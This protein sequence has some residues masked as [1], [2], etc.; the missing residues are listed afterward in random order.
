[1]A[2]TDFTLIGAD[3]ADVSRGVSA[4]FTPPNGGSNYV[5]GF[6]S[7]ISEP[8]AVCAYYNA[9]NF[10]PLRDASSNAT[11]GSVRA[12]LKRGVAGAGYSI[13]LFINLQATVI[14]DSTY[15]LGLSNNDPYSIVLA[16]LSPDTPLDSTATHKLRVSSTNYSTQDWFHLRL[17]AIVNPNG[18]V[19]LK[20]FQNDLDTNPVTSPSWAAITGMDDIID[21]GL[22]ITSG[23]NPLSGG[24]AGYCFKAAQLNAY[25]F[26][27]Q[28]EIYRQK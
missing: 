18:D 11:G 16:K 19:V 14:T 21:D 28:F 24:Y 15:M 7:L 9:A 27:D 5:F 13:G 25:G 17:D 20:C 6:N 3:A 1:M 10:A 12:A 26:V 4:S 2:E 23:S 22:G 8:D